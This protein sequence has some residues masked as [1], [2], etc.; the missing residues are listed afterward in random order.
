[1]KDDWKSKLTGKIIRGAL[2]G[3]ALHQRIGEGLATGGAL[4]LDVGD[5]AAR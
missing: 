1:M 5:G 4:A 3:H 2:G